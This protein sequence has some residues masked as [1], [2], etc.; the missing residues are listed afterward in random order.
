MLTS[1][2]TLKKDIDLKERT[3]Q[4]MSDLETEIKA[5]HSLRSRLQSTVNDTLTSAMKSDNKELATHYIEEYDDLVNLLNIVKSA[6]MLLQN[7]SVKIDSARY[8]NEFVVILETAMVSLRVI[9][10]DISRI[11]PAVDNTL[12]TISNSIREI[13]ADL[14]IKELTTQRDE[15]P[16]VMPEIG[17]D[18]P[19]TRAKKTVDVS[20]INLTSFTTA[21]HT[22]V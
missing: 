16:T 6:E 15:L 22:L 20:A 19:S 12:D 14:K 2:F 11:V 3:Y 5:M 21:V 7:L 17:I 13:K 1:F 9:K 4:A 10:S 18:L 8:L